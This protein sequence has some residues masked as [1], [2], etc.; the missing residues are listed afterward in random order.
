MDVQEH[1]EFILTLRELLF[2]V[3]SDQLH[4]CKS[5]FGFWI[6]IGEEEPVHILALRVAPVVATDHPIRVR[7]G[8]DPKLITVPELLAEGFSGH[9]EVHKAMKNETAVSL[10]RVLTSDYENHRLLLRV[11]SFRFVRNLDDRYV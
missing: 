10:A 11:V 5:E 2:Q 7:H 3:R 8:H 4:F 6:V 9:Y 1:F